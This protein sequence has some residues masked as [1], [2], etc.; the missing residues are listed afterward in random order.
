[1][2]F[3]IRKKSVIYCIGVIFCINYPAIQNRIKFIHF[4]QRSVSPTIGETLLNGVIYNHF[5]RN[6]FSTGYQLFL[7][8]PIWLSK[9][10]VYEQFCKIPSGSTVFGWFTI[11][12]SLV[13]L[14]KYKN[15]ALACSY[16]SVCCI[17]GRYAASCLLCSTSL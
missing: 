15:I 4:R 5:M 14:Y 10:Q 7:L 8:L 11:R 16:V 3:Y 17:Y 6:L 9:E 12:G 2:D 1:M 13:S